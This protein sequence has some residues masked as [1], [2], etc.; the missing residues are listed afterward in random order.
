ME[1]THTPGPWTINT[2]AFETGIAIE[3]PPFSNGHPKIVA[4]VWPFDDTQGARIV[5]D[6]IS[7][8]NAKLIKAA[9]TMLDALKQVRANQRVALMLAVEFPQLAVVIQDA[10]EDAAGEDA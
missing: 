2:G 3:G 10:I 4:E 6:E 8:A 7:M 1:T 5:E 9:P